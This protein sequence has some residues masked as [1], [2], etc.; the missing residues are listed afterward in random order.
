[1]NK[2]LIISYFHFKRNTD[3]TVEWYLLTIKSTMGHKDKSAEGI[4]NQRQRFCHHY[5]KKTVDVCQDI[6]FPESLYK[7]HCYYD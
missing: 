5:N 2:A 1:M 4:Q 7:Y 6:V 3:D